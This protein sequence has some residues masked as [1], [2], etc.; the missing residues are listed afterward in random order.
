MSSPTLLVEIS[1]HLATLRR[2]VQ[3]VWVSPKARVML[4]VLK[5]SSVYQSSQ[6]THLVIKFLWGDLDLMTERREQTGKV[7][8]D[9][10]L[11]GH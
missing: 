7:D 3:L 11:A 10:K 6:I 9:M 5:E 2:R 4:K 1:V 8:Q